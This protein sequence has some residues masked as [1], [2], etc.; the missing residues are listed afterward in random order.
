MTKIKDLV[1]RSCL[2]GSMEGIENLTTLR[3]IELYDNQIEEIV[4]L[5]NL[6]NLLILDLSFNAIRSM[7]P[8][9][10]SCCPILEGW[11]CSVKFQCFRLFSYY[12]LSYSILLLIKSLLLFSLLL[13]S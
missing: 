6:S 9:L 12:V 5:G 3:K 11:F 8:N 4:G 7:I 1:L 13:L 2:V 10:A